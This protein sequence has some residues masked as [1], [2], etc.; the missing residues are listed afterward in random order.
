LVSRDHGNVELDQRTAGVEFSVE[1]RSPA[2]VRR[3]FDLKVINLELSAA[4]KK[5]VRQG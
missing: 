1:K 2:S 5:H 4:R 3:T